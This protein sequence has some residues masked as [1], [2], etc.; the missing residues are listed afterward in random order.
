MKWVI[1]FSKNIGGSPPQ[2]INHIS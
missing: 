1:N 2:E